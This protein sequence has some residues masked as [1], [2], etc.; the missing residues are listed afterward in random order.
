MLLPVDPEITEQKSSRTRIGHGVTLSGGFNRTHQDSALE[1]LED[2]PRAQ[3]RL[4]RSRPIPFKI[5]IALHII[6]II[7]IK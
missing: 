5:I 2:A 6:Y 7:I 1:S 4:P 3:T